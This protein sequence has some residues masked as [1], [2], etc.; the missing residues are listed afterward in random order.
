MQ[1]NPNIGT[2][3]TRI[4]EKESGGPDVFSALQ[5]VVEHPALKWAPKGVPKDKD[6]KDYVVSDK[7]S[8]VV[9]FLEWRKGDY[10]PYRVA[11]L[12]QKDR[13]RLEV[14]GWGTVLG[15]W[16][17]I[18]RI[19]DGLAVTYRGQAPASKPGYNDTDVFDVIVVRDGRRISRDEPKDEPKDE[20][21][22]FEGA[23]DADLP[24]D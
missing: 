23:E 12:V 1:D 18:L 7:V 4:V 8:G 3:A 24:L 16:F 22:T 19:G 17:P 15:A 20:E 6:A 10:D 13:S 9:E 11:S 21:I 5:D 14:S 2:T